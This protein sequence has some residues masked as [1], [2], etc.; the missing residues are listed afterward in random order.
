TEHAE[1][2]AKLA[3]VIE[4]AGSDIA[5]EAVRAPVETLVGVMAP[6]DRVIVPEPVIGLPDTPMPLL[7][8]TPTDV[9]VPPPPVAVMVKVPVPG[10][11]DTPDPATMF[12][13]PGKLE[14]AFA[15]APKCSD[16]VSALSSL[17]TRWRSCVTVACPR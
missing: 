13:I 9:T 3:R 2:L 4:A 7:P 14:I 6:S 5:P 17:S 8:D 11:N 12:T 10:V 1:P 15:D 16:V